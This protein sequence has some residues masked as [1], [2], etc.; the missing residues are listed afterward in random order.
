MFDGDDEV[1]ASTSALAPPF[2]DDAT[3]LVGVYHGDDAIVVEPDL[4]GTHLGPL[5]DHAPPTGRRL[6]ARMAGLSV[7]DGRRPDQ[8]RAGYFDPGIILGQLGL[9]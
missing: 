4:L 3:E 1:P 7:P 8:L 5:S 2:P 9:G 6:R